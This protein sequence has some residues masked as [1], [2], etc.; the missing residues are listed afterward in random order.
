[1]L[2][3]LPLPH[4][5]LRPILTLSTS[6]YETREGLIIGTHG[7]KNNWR[8]PSILRRNAIQDSELAMLGAREG[9]HVSGGRQGAP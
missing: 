9:G 8:V 4:S 2:A 3:S 6:P 1:M 7:R 5:A